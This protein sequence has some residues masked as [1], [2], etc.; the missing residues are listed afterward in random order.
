[1]H[2]KENTHTHTHFESVHM[3]NL[4]IS[5]EKKGKHRFKKKTHTP[6]E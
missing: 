1:M 6:N 5:R 3:L 2:T 4:I